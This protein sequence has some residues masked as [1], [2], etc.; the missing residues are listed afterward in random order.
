MKVK[1]KCWAIFMSGW[2][3][4]TLTGNTFYITPNTTYLT[5]KSAKAAAER[6]AKKLG[7]E[8]EWEK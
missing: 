6:L 8:I 3:D 5:E 2:I 1:G 4:W 7:L